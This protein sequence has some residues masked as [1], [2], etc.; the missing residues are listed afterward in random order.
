[1]AEVLLAKEFAGEVNESFNEVVIGKFVIKHDPNTGRLFVGHIGKRQI[2]T[3][4]IFMNR[5]NN[6]MNA[7]VVIGREGY[8]V[9]EIK[10]NIL[11]TME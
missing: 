5:R 11:I 6:K 9:D 4:Y 8:Y 10:K 2:R 1:M 7:Y 3:F